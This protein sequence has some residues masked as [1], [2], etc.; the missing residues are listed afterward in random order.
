MQVVIQVFFVALC[1]NVNQHPVHTGRT[2]TKRKTLKSKNTKCVAVT[3]DTVHYY[4]KQ[5]AILQTGI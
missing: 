5:N 4:Y 3:I 2:I 1:N